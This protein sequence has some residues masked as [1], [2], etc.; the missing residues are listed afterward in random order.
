MSEKIVAF[1]DLHGNVRQ[2]EKISARIREEEATYVLFAGDM[3]FTQLGGHRDTFY[4]LCGNLVTVRGNIDQPWVFMTE[5]IKVPLMYTSIMFGGGRLLSLTAITFPPGPPCRYS[6][7][8]VISS[9]RDT[10][11]SPRSSSSQ[12][13]QRSSIP[14]R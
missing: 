9:S 4:S 8:I 11:I 14:V 2:L 12:G 5:G 1:S 3:G 7:R 10:P 13:S 6:Y